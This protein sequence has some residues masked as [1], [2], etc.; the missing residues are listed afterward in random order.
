MTRTRSKHATQKVMFWKQIL[1]IGTTGNRSSVGKVKLI[2]N[3]RKKLTIPQTKKIPS[4]KSSHN[5]IS[6]QESLDVLSEEDE[7]IKQT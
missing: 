7:E 1:P 6:E 2:S 5:I 3:L 4:S